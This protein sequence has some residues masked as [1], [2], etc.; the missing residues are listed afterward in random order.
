LTPDLTPIIALAHGGDDAPVRHAPRI[1]A[2]FGTLTSTAVCGCT[3]LLPLSRSVCVGLVVHAGSRE[4][5]KTR[6]TDSGAAARFTC[7]L[8]RNPGRS[9]RSSE[10]RA[11]AMD[12]VRGPRSRVC[13]PL[14]RP[15]EVDGDA[16]AEQPDQL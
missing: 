9:A 6:S 13:L 15:A 2:S 11:L 3:A 8:R 7:R 5:L 16:D 4:C 14:R 10:R 12:Q 1:V